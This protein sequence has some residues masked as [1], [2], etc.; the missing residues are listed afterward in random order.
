MHVAAMT[1]CSLAP[2]CLRL[3]GT[4]CFVFS[5]AL[6]MES[7][8]WKFS[9]ISQ[10]VYWLGSG[11]NSRRMDFRPLVEARLLS[12]LCTAQTGSVVYPVSQSWSSAV[13]FLGLKRPGRE[14]GCSPS[15]EPTLR[16]C[17][18]LPPFPIGIHRVLLNQEQWQLYRCAS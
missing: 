8:I 5:S 9:H 6:K 2:E 14:P 11:L 3:R 15:S 17:G 4:V 12:F 16:I 10:S 18:A 1:P 13:C 7:S